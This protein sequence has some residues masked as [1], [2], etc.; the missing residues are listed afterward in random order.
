MIFDQKKLITNTGGSFSWADEV[1]E[2]LA[3]A[4]AQGPPLG[5]TAVPQQDKTPIEKIS[6]IFTPKVES[7]EIVR[8]PASSPVQLRDRPSPSPSSEAPPTNRNSGILQS[9][10]ATAPDEPVVSLDSQAAK[11]AVSLEG[12]GNV[13]ARKDKKPRGTKSGKK[14]SKQG[15]KSIGIR[16]TGSPKISSKETDSQTKVKPSNAHIEEAGSPPKSVGLSNSKSAKLTREV[17][18]DSPATTVASGPGRKTDDGLAQTPL[19]SPRRNE[20]SLSMW[21]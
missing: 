11:K 4:A 2:E 3:G 21:A 14:D 7:K 17:A 1:E 12:G 19:S 18:N 6:H 5:Q 15:R 20:M 13:V 9:R 8:T 16:L 10:W